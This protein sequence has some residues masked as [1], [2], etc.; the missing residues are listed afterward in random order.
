MTPYRSLIPA[1]LVLGLTTAC[2]KTQEAAKAPTSSAETTQASYPDWNGQIA[3]APQATVDPKAVQAIQAMSA[4]LSGLKTFKLNTVGTMDV[5]TDDGQRIQI[6][7]TTQYEAKKPGIV[8]RYNSDLK[9][10]EFYY[11]GKN[12]TTYSPALGFYS[13]V[14]AP[15]TNK[16]FLDQVYDHYGIRLPLEDL[17]RW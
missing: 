9:K 16:E 12:F 14:P 17:F 15:P 8:I 7:G 3:P 1:I 11:D 2:S 10:R 5:V 4:Y 6:D 13:T